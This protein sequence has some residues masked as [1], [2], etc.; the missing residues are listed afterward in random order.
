MENTRVRSTS[1]ASPAIEEKKTTGSIFCVS[2]I[3]AFPTGV[4]ARK[5]AVTL[6]YS[7]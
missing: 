1:K 3:G 6:K 7:R 5:K 2:S 4:V